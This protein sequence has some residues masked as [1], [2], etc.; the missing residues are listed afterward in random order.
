MHALMAE[1]ER[2]GDLAQRTAREVQSTDGRVVFS[3]GEKCLPIRVREL[4][5]SL[6]RHVQ[7]VLIEGHGRNVYHA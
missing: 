1:G 3:P 5:A 4:A 2:F 7:Q 6:A